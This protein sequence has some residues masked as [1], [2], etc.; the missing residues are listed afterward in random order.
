M[1]LSVH[2]EVVEFSLNCIHWMQAVQQRLPVHFKRQQGCSV[3]EV[4][5]GLDGLHFNFEMARMFL[6]MPS[7]PTQVG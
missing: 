5:V 6:T 3:F 2:D 4:V 7:C 1:L